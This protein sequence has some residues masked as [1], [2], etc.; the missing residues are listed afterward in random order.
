[1]KAKLP[2]LFFCL[3][4]TPALASADI[5][6]WVDDRGVVSFT[7]NLGNIPAK[8]RAKAVQV[9][10]PVE[11]VQEVV[12][13]SGGSKDKQKSAVAAKSD[14][15]ESADDAKKKKMFGGKD[16]ATWKREAEKLNFQVTDTESQLS[17]MR[18]R[19]SDTSKMSRTEYLS[20]QNSVKLM[21]QRLATQK[22]QQ[23][24]FLDS[25]RKAGAPL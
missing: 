4:L 13:E 17:E 11:A 16:E 15:D 3:L 25:A 10:A 5:F 21:E 18:S 6:R 20:L 9:D 19:L 2:L 23:E 24:Q 14:K 8:F 22:G 12:V 1:M 7:D